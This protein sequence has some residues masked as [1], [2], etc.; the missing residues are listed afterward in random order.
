MAFE[1]ILGVLLREKTK[2]DRSL[3]LTGEDTEVIYWRIC[4]ANLG[5]LLEPFS[6][7]FLESFSLRIYDFFD[8]LWE[9]S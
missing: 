7:R 9:L 1:M 6:S 4:E 2:N 5:L 3:G 8:D